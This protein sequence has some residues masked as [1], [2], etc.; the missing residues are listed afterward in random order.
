MGVGI[1]GAALLG[2]VAKTLATGRGAPD[3]A[4]ALGEALPQ[5]QVGNIPDYAGSSSYDYYDLSSGS[6]T[7]GYDP[8]LINNHPHSLDRN[9]GDWLDHVT[10]GSPGSGTPGSG[11]PGSG[12]PG[13]GTPGSGT[14]GSGTPGSGTP[15]SGTPG[16]GTPGS[17]TPG[18]GTPG[19]GTPGSGTPGSGSPGPIREGPGWRDYGTYGT[20]TT[21]SWGDS[22]GGESLGSDVSDSLARFSEIMGEE[23]Y[24]PFE[25]DEFL[26]NFQGGLA[27]AESSAGG[28]F[29]ASAV[30]EQALAAAASTGGG[31][32]NPDIRQSS[33]VQN[34]A[35]TAA[36]EQHTDIERVNALIEAGVPAIDIKDTWK[37][38][39]EAMGPVDGSSVEEQYN[40]A[41]DALAEHVTPQDVAFAE[42]G[43][44]AA[45]GS[46]PESFKNSLR[47]AGFP[48]EAL[49]S[50]VDSVKDA[51]QAATENG[52]N[53]V[54]SAI[55]TI[56]NAFPPGAGDT[57][58][59]GVRG[60]NEAIKNALLDVLRASSNFWPRYAN[61]VY[62]TLK[63]LEGKPHSKTLDE[64]LANG[65][66][67]K[68]P[69]YR[70]IGYPYRRGKIP[71]PGKEPVPVKP[72]EDYADFMHRNS[73][74]PFFCARRTIKE[75]REPA[76]ADTKAVKDGLKNL[77]GDQH[78]RDTYL[79][80]L[81]HDQD[82]VSRLLEAVP[83]AICRLRAYP[84]TVGIYNTSCAISKKPCNPDD[85]KSVV[86]EETAQALLRLWN[87]VLK[88]KT[89]PIEVPETNYCTTISSKQFSEANFMSKQSL[90][91]VLAKYDNVNKTA[92]EKLA[93]HDRNTFIWMRTWSVP[94]IKC[95]I[96]ME[97]ESPTLSEKERTEYQGSLKMMEE[98]SRN[99][100]DI[101]EADPDSDGVKPAPSTTRDGSTKP[102]STTAKPTST[103]TKPTSTT[104]KSTSTTAKPTPTETKPDSLNVPEF[105]LPRG[106]VCP[107][108]KHHKPPGEKDPPWAIKLV[109]DK[110]YAE[111]LKAF[112]AM[113]VQAL[114]LFNHHKDEYL[115]HLQ[116]H[117]DKLATTIKLVDDVECAMRVVD[118]VA[119]KRYRAKLNVFGL[120]RLAPFDVDYSEFDPL[121]EKDARIGTVDW[122]FQ[123]L[124]RRNIRK[125]LRKGK[126]TGL[127]YEG[128][129]KRLQALL[130]ALREIEK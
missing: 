4:N 52:A 39:E 123:Q 44:A 21:D 125:Y 30:V 111:Q 49:D 41:L 18:S 114:D 81:K 85:P 12:T 42:A 104:A 19:S 116:S 83:N 98:V 15:G 97:L 76:K 9:V 50:T 60:P 120:G 23:G 73:T 20:E 130:N 65:P 34:A 36:E 26:R 84:D 93:K 64:I 29:G 2:W 89:T 10:E 45:R 100:Y 126:I 110:T 56:R 102:T 101:I 43:H 59:G 14:P 27:H 48:E 77:N 6:A 99:S 32:L 119:E 124:R 8:N 121:M 67:P 74:V 115:R 95:K 35:R 53:P 69:L 13:S 113:S 106:P 57:S 54:G 33:L 79:T 66:P 70:D 128:T 108:F 31:G 24:D 61:A 107:D 28:G 105:K 87:S 22:F 127:D 16:S 96:H 38:M 112:R 103:T 46:D 5:A 80:N 7:S 37:T 17:G 129:K 47:H 117:P 88:S 118:T 62:D 51:I 94:I 90:S 75:I 91:D 58:S 86:H 72:G 3:V 68:M 55:D 122:V 92:L 40:A 25:S 63:K 71:G 11:T 78:L 109:E 82:K 1:P